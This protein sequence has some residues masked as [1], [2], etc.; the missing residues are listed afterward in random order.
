MCITSVKHREHNTGPAFCQLWSR[1]HYMSTKQETNG[2]DYNRDPLPKDQ[3]HLH[4]PKLN[5]QTFQTYQP[6][7]L[8]MPLPLNYYQGL[9]FQFQ[10]FTSKFLH[11]GQRSSATIWPCVRLGIILEKRK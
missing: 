1:E 2:V 3:T 10:V 4:I 6:S 11:T 9:C 7:S 8:L 5:T